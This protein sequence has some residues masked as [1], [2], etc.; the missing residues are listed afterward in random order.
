MVDCPHWGGRRETFELIVI[1]FLLL[2]YFS[3]PSIY[4]CD[5]YNFMY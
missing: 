5:N 1:L 2:L 4:F 3:A